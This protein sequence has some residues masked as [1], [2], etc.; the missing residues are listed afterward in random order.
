MHEILPKFL[1]QVLITIASVGLL[2]L[3]VVI[4]VLRRSLFRVSWQQVAVSWEVK[5]TKALNVEWTEYEIKK[6]MIYKKLS[7]D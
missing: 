3:L 5:T 4:S 7:I 2:V 1:S 6:G